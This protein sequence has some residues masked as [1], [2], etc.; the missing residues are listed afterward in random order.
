MVFKSLNEISHNIPKFLPQKLKFKGGKFLFPFAKSQ[1]LFSTSGTLREEGMM[2]CHMTDY[3]P[4][5]GI[6][7]TTRSATGAMRDSVHFSVNHSVL[8]HIGGDWSNKKFAIL[9]PLKGARNMSGNSFAGGIATDFYSIGPVKIPPNSII[10]RHN[11]KLPKG[12]YRIVN[13]SEFK[14]LTGLKKCR[15][16][17][18]S[19][20][21]FQ[22]AVDDIISKSGY[23]LR[24]TQDSFVWGT[25]KRNGHGNKR[26]FKNFRKFNE[27][28]KANGMTPMAHTYTPN[29]KAEQLYEN[30]TLLRHTSNNWIVRNDNGGILINH[31]NEILNALDEIIEQASKGFYPVS[32]DLQKI[33]NIILKAETPEIAIKELESLGIVRSLLNPQQIK[34]L[35][36][37]SSKEQ[38]KSAIASRRLLVGGPAFGKIDS[39]VK[40]YIDF[41][42]FEKLK[43]L[44]TDRSLN[45]EI[46]TLFSELA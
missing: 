46:T 14:E 13:T 35:Q 33:K 2:L 5:G 17:E 34:Q 10:V 42:T 23:E 22:E 18:T 8:G 43:S 36:G 15:V 11:S 9:M 3:I 37:L 1:S 12:K 41:P 45:D 30:I 28:L 24:Q 39:N 32:F 26:S 38:I 29:G 25:L 4:K 20:P 44:Y 16:I 40:D 21:N 7:Q 19:N 31:K 6:I 27:Y